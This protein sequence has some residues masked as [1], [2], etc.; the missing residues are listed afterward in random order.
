[1]LMQFPVQPTAQ[2]VSKKAVL[3]ALKQAGFP[4]N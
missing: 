2:M 3:D 1:M 4:T